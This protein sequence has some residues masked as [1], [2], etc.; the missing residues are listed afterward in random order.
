MISF[1]KLNNFSKKVQ[2]KLNP[3]IEFIA[4]NF[5]FIFGI[6]P[7]SLTAKLINKRF[8]EKN[9]KNSNWKKYNSN[10]NYKKM[11]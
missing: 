1:E 5:I 8:L 3:K 7:T 11:Y 4:L 9:N 6:T 2:K 10:N